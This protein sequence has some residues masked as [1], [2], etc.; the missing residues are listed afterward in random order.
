ML[1]S[2]QS[3]RL[4]GEYVVEVQLDNRVMFVHLN[5]GDRTGTEIIDWSFDNNEFAVD[6]TTYVT[7][8][9]PTNTKLYT[10]AKFRAMW[11]RLKDLAT[12]V[13]YDEY[14][15]GGADIEALA[16]AAGIHN[17]KLTVDKITLDELAEFET[18]WKLNQTNTR[19]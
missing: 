6:T 12:K 1:D 8:V 19:K 17:S 16:K 10:T 18:K 2:I 4:Q 7:V 3:S 11:P 9:L 5:N 15:N 13:S 14:F